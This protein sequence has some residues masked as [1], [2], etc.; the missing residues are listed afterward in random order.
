MA[1]DSVSAVLELFVTN[2]NQPMTFDQIYEAVGDGVDKEQFRK[3][4]DEEI[5]LMHVD[6]KYSV[7]PDMV[8]AISYFE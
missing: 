3:M 4:L 6:D 7:A 5:C 2:H 8:F 1:K